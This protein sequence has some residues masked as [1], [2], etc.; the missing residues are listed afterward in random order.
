MNPSVIILFMCLQNLGGGSLVILN[1]LITFITVLAFKGS[2]NNSVNVTC[3]YNPNGLDSQQ[4]KVHK[5][6][7]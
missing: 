6:F 4:K 1:Q 2:Y 7:L 5:Q 3:Y